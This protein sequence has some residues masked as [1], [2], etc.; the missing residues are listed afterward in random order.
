MNGLFDK[1]NSPRDP[2]LKSLWY[3]V[4]CPATPDTLEGINRA[5]S[6]FGIKVPN[7]NGFV[8]LLET[9]DADFQPLPGF[10]EWITDF[11]KAKSQVY[12]LAINRPDV[13]MWESSWSF[14]IA[15][16]YSEMDLVQSLE[17]DENEVIAH[18]SQHRRERL[19]RIYRY[20]EPMKYYVS[21][22]PGGK[23]FYGILETLKKVVE[24]SCVYE[25]MADLELQTGQL[26]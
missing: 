26:V 2:E 22:T 21:A 5:G 9:S 23:G 25:P 24:S 3:L 17:L 12:E 1:H 14:S 19:N 16:T 10:K 20:K 4:H 15:Q 6:V 13:V 7:P 18:A 11:W 8:E